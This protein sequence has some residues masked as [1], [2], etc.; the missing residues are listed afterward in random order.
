MNMNENTKCTTGTCNTPN[1]NEMTDTTGQGID[2]EPII[3]D[4]NEQTTDQTMGFQTNGTTNDP[5]NDLSD[6]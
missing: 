1:M 4:N 6:C 3:Q 2:Q 5:D